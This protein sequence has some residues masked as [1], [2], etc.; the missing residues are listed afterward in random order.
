MLV[1]QLMPMT[2][3]GQA[4]ASNF[5]KNLFP[6]PD[7]NDIYKNCYKNGLFKLKKSVLLSFL[8]VMETKIIFGSFMTAEMSIY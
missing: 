6:I 8:D 2:F 1:V 4:P 3:K 5:K 7:F